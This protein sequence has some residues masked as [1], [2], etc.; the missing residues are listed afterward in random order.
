MALH[1][2][3][4]HDG[5]ID[6]EAGGQ[7]DTEQGE[8]VDAEVERLDE[9]EGADQR[10]GDGDGGDDGSAPVEQEQEDDHDDDADGFEQ[11]RV[12]GDAVG[13]YRDA[14]AVM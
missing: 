12:E 1:V 4:D 6:D 14:V 5:V 3:D 8:G 10:D 11:R 2:L 13:E 7:R 9:G